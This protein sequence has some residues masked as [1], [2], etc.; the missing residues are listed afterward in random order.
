MCLGNGRTSQRER[1]RESGG[2]RGGFGGCGERVQR[3]SS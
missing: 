1:E 3:L 2:G